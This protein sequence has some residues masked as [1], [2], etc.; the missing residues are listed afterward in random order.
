MEHNK[1]NLRIGSN[2]TNQNSA[3]YLE[4]LFPMKRCRVYVRPKRLFSLWLKSVQPNSPLSNRYI[5]TS[6]GKKRGEGGEV[7]TQGH[8]WRKSGISV[9]MC[10]T[11]HFVH[12]GDGV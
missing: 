9:A 1:H 5:S 3:A 8:T 2:V 7:S 11:H 10:G 6:K 4:C 12:T